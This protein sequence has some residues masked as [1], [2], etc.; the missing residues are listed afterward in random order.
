MPR[1]RSWRKALT[2]SDR[3][4]IHPVYKSNRVTSDPRKTS[5]YSPHIVMKRKFNSAPLDDPEL[6]FVG[7]DDSEYFTEIHERKV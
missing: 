2:K 5:V 1:S 7:D 6:T 4:P 3:A